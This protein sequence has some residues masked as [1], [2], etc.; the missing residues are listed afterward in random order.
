MN[1]G[2]RASARRLR[3]GASTVVGALILGLLPPA[4]A[5]PVQGS[6]GIYTCTDER[7]RRLS[8]DRPIPECLTKEQR[9]LNRDG[10]LKAVRPPSLTP[11]ERTEKEASERLRAEQRAAQA[12]AAR[13]DRNLLQRYRDEAAHRRARDAALAPVRAAQLAT[14]SRIAEVRR[15]RDPLL[16]E[17]EFYRGK[18]LPPRLKAQLDAN[19]ASLAALRDSAAGQQGEVARIDALYDAE[20]ERLRRLWGG[21]APGSLGP[22]APAAAAAGAASQV[23]PARGSRD[24]K[25]ASAVTSPSAPGSTAGR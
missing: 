1:P 10:S 3:R 12:D 7:G 5:Q 20:L 6:G 24:A 9:I 4:G 14:Q 18:P 21:A 19:D 25:A 8:S 2:T 22:M 13:R 11:E 15:E 16:A 23:A 17:A